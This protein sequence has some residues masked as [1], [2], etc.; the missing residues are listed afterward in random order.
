MNNLDAYLSRIYTITK[1]PPRIVVGEEEPSNRTED[2]LV[3]WANSA[4]R[5]LG[6]QND[7]VKGL[8]N[9]LATIVVYRAAVESA[10][11]KRNEAMWSRR[12]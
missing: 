1:Q 3:V 11:G 6:A 4:V 9:L 12:A 7:Q 8:I 5:Q 10:L 2:A